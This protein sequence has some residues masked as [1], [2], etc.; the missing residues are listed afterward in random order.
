MR[1]RIHGLYLIEIPYINEI[2]IHIPV[3]KILICTK[4]NLYIPIFKRTFLDITFLATTYAQYHLDHRNIQYKFNKFSRLHSLSESPCICY[5]LRSIQVCVNFKKK[6]KK[7]EKK[8]QFFQ[9]RWDSYPRSL[10]DRQ[11]RPNHHPISS[12]SSKTLNV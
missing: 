5:I 11:Y 10:H 12:Q 1:S 9:I 6:G 2:Y 3:S 7:V 4:R 8:V